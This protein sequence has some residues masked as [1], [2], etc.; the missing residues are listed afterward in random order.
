MDRTF[1]DV[2][3][4]LEV[5]VDEEG[6]RNTLAGMARVCLNTIEENGIP[7]PRVTGHAEGVVFVWETGESRLMMTMTDDNRHPSL[8]YEYEDGSHYSRDDLFWYWPS[9]LRTF[10]RK[11]IP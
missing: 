6:L 7:P 11:P 10:F 3:S 9:A 8:I 1:A 2:R 5:L 4:T